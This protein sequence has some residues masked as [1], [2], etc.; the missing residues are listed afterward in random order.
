MEHQR[1][2]LPAVRQHLELPV[3]DLRAGTVRFD[4]NAGSP[5]EIG[6]ADIEGNLECH[7]NGNFTTG[8]LTPFQKG[9][10]DG[11]TS[12]QCAAF[13]VK[14]DNPGIFPGPPPW[15]MVD[16]GSPGAG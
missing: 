1:H 8:V 13:A 15:V 7:G 16:P 6:G 3:P 2:Q 11:T 9:G 12:G 5:N 4:D 14:G 10:V